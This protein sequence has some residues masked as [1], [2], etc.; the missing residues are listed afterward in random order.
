MR[1]PLA[2]MSKIPPELVDPPPG[3]FQALS[4]FLH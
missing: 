3:G 1:L 2:S 4:L